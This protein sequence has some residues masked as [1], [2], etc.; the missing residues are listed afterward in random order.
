MNY[1]EEK[2]LDKFFTYHCLHSTLH[3]NEYFTIPHPHYQC[4]NYGQLYTCIVQDPLEK[5]LKYFQGP[6]NPLYT[7]CPPPNNQQVK[8]PTSL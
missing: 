5:G 7:T 8:S 1:L 3:K 6:K 2:E 4:H